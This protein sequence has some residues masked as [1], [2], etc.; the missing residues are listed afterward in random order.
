MEAER[1]VLVTGAN[2]GIGRAT[3]AA[4][5]SAE[6]DSAVLLGSRDR[7]RGE[8]ARSFLIGHNPTWSERIRVT[9][10]DVGDDNSVSSAAG[11]VGA[12]FG[13]EPRPLYGIINNAGIGFGSADMGTV[14]NVN[15]LGPRRVCDA[16]LPLLREGGR[17]I[18][19]S[20][21]SGPNFVSAC[22]AARKQQLTD[23]GVTWPQ[24]QSLM[25]E[26]LALDQQ[27]SDLATAG[28]GDGSAYGLSKALLICYTM[29]MARSHPELQIN[30]CTPG[31]IETDLTRPFATAQG[32]SPSALGMKSPEQGTK[33][34]IHLLF[35]EPGGS[36]WYF[37]SDAVR[38]PIDRYRSPGDPP[39]TGD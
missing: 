24:I 37:G 8:E 33:A 15:T 30:A 18:N 16:F 11:D 19:I 21:A 29:L 14:L 13:T 6:A 27:G 9:E 39:Y 22:S 17:V 26:C 32:A 3:V 23:S 36:G 38:S 2:K 5:L 25:D 28:F 31:W 35:G 7:G 34:A 20:S 10:I 12:R 1:L 4:V